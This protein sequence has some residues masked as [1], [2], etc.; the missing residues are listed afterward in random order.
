MKTGDKE[1]AT[2]TFGTREEI[3]YYDVPELGTVATVRKD[4]MVYTV[5][6]IWGPE[7]GMTDRHQLVSADK[8]HDL[9]RRHAASL[10]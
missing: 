4:I 9:A 1:I 8:A 2:H 6:L 7:V 3:T 5:T 10:A